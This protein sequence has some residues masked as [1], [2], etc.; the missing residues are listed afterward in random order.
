MTEDQEYMWAMLKCE[1]QKLC[2]KWADQMLECQNN[3]KT[4]NAMA[5]EYLHY[6]LDR[7]SH[8]DTCRTI[9][10]WLS[11]YHLPIDPGLISSFDRFHVN[12]GPYVIKNLGSITV[13]EKE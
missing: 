10:T 3:A 1:P 6:M 13:F 5:D 11:T 8:N 12:C 7:F 4:M 2:H 9:K